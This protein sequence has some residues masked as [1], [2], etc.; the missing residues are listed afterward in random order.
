[1]TTLQIVLRSIACSM[2]LGFGWG[3]LAVMLLLG[4]LGSSSGGE[5]LGI[6]PNA[7]AF[8]G[9]IGAAV[10]LVVGLP[11][12]LIVCPLPSDL[13]YCRQVGAVFATTA[14]GCVH[15]VMAMVGGWMGWFAIFVILAL[16]VAWS[17]WFGLGWIFSPAAGAVR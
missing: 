10:G 8:G 12:A 3:T 2:G 17:A 15:A 4:D 14:V 13:P 16:P 1:M 5:L 11:T 6:L 7:A 9:G